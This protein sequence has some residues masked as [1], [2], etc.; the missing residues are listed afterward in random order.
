[1]AKSFT[2]NGTDFGGA[3]YDLTLLDIPQ[4]PGMADPR[5]EKFILSGA[6]GARTGAAFLA[7]L[8]FSMTCMVQG[9]THQ[10]LIE[11]MN[12]IRALLDPRLGEQLLVIDDETNIAATV[13]RGYYARLNG[14]IHIVSETLTYFKFQLNWMVP[15]GHA[16]TDSVI[17]Q[18]GTESAT[19]PYVLTVP[20]GS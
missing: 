15:S 10:D 5:M 12:R 13:N 9:S 19:S 7:P 4:L 18:I 1:M 3:N 2:Y 6:D 11:N 20:G 16:V 8:Y 17:T 14:P